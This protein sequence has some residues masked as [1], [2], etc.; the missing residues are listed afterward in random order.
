MIKFTKVE[1]F[2]RYLFNKLDDDP[3]SGPEDYDDP[4]TYNANQEKYVFRSLYETTRIQA[5][6][7]G[8]DKNKFQLKGKI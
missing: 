8:A 1:P 6:Q 2:G 5:S 3:G 4:T 7:I